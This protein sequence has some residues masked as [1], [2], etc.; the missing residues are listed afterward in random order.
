M[1]LL[2]NK[3]WFSCFVFL[4]WNKRTA[5]LETS[6]V[7]LLF[8][9]TKPGLLE[10]QNKKALLETSI[11]FLLFLET[12]LCYLLLV[13]LCFFFFLKQI[14]VFLFGVSSLKQCRCLLW[15]VLET[16]RRRAVLE[17][18]RRR[19]KQQKKS[20]AAEEERFLKQ[21]EEERQPFL[22]LKQTLL[23]L[24]QINKSFY[25]FLFCLET[26]PS[27]LETNKQTFRVFL[28]LL[29]PEKNK[30][31]RVF[32]FFCLPFLKQIDKKLL[33]YFF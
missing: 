7:F 11:V 9:E 3:T 16:S 31:F 8:L 14:V 4:L 5:L 32:L 28:L 22:F 13:T 25:S 2:W 26:N 6:I 29:L 18:S 12:K 10:Q 24:K 17:T 1:F 27:F 23:F 20:E 15:A 21:A 19:A 30:N 33:L